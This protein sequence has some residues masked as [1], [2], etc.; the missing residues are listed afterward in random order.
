[1]H[2][3]CIFSKGF[4][5]LCINFSRVWTKN[6][7][8]CEISKGLIKF[9]NDFLRILFQIIHLAYLSEKVTI[10]ALIFHAFGRKPRIVEKFSENFESFDEN[11]QT[12]FEF[13]INFVIFLTKN[14]AFGNNIIFL[15]QFLS[16]SVGFPPFPPLATP[17][18]GLL[19][20]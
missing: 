8:S 17:L 10:P 6:T 5:K 19:L 1:M 13:L 9:S 16:V 11:K 15:Q 2:Y 7:N 4:K 14:R 3:F 18:D 20:N 12:N